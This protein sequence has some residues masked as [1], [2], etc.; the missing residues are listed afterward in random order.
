MA[1]LSEKYSICEAGEISCL[2]VP[3]FPHGLD[4]ITGHKK[5]PLLFQAEKQTN[6][7]QT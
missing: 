4:E 3:C 6:N 7:K 5:E 2:T 1:Q